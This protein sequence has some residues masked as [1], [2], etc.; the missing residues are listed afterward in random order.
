MRIFQATLEPSLLLGF[1]CDK[2]E[3]YDKNSVVG[4]PRL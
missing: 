1:V 3:F 2:P 4:V